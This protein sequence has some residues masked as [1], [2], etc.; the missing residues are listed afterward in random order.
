MKL[1]CECGNADPSRF[2]IVEERTVWLNVDHIDGVFLQVGGD[3][4]EELT[5]S[6]RLW[7][8]ECGTD[9]EIK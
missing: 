2:S 4:K 3:L 7:C 5:N 9:Q 8:D 1:T 6:T